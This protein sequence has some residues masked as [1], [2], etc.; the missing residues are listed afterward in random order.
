[1][2]LVSFT[3]SYTEVEPNFHSIVR[4]HTTLLKHGGR[5]TS[6]MD[7]ITTPTTPVKF[8]KQTTEKFK[9]LTIVIG[10]FRGLSSSSFGSFFEQMKCHT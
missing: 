4:R 3:G 5:V 9:P 2:S 10:R 7:F 6:F 1:M 8:R